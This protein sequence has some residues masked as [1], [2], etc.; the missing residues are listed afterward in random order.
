[1]C[2][3]EVSSESAIVILLGLTLALGLGDPH[4]ISW[5]YNRHRHRLRQRPC[6]VSSV[7]CRVLLNRPPRPLNRPITPT[8][9]LFENSNP[10]PA[11]GAD[12]PPRTSLQPPDGYLCSVKCT[13]PSTLDAR[14][15][16]I[17]APDSPSARAGTRPAATRL[18]VYIWC[19]RTSTVLHCIVLHVGPPVSVQV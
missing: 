14:R 5:P 13:A 6:W 1:M 15:D 18:A 16:P 3:R 2:S 17:L 9:L 10:H 11:R 12:S 7:E 19:V 8:S 4:L